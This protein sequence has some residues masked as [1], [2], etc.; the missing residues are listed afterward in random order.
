MDEFTGPAFPCLHVH[1]LRL[2]SLARG[3]FECLGTTVYRRTDH[4]AARYRGHGTG[5]L[6]AARKS[7]TAVRRGK[8]ARYRNSPAEG[9]SWLFSQRSGPTGANNSSAPCS[10][11]AAEP[12]LRVRRGPPPFGCEFRV[13]R[14]GCEFRVFRTALTSAGNPSLREDKASA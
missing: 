13:F 2:T 5:R 11:S 4:S 9:H 6:V 12:E 3:C 1:V 10:G 8:I 14:C 7:H